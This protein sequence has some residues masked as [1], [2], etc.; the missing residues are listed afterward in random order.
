MTRASD[1]TRRIFASCLLAALLSLG[2]GR[3]LAAPPE[4]QSSA[5]ST[6]RPGTIELGAA[7]VLPASALGLAAFGAVELG[8]A[9][10]HL[11]SCQALAMVGGETSAACRLDPPPLAFVSVGLSW[12]LAIPLLVGGSLLFARG[13]AQ[14]RHAREQARGPSLQLRPNLELRAGARLANAGAT[15]QL[16]F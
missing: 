11:A 5:R 8:R 9:Q 7:T 10:D 3:V 2:P 14:R 12:A 4:A 13:A 1:G 6:P 15:L 16:N